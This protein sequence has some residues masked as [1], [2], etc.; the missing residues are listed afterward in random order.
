MSPQHP[1]AERLPF[2][3]TALPGVDPAWS[4][5]LTVAATAPVEPVAGRR[6]RWHVLDNA[7]AIAASG[8]TPQGIVL[9]VH[10]NPTWSYLW[11]D[12]LRA[13][14]EAERPWRVVAVDQ[15]DMG[16]SE[17]TGLFRRLE[18]RVQDL[19]DLT[20]ALG[21]D[22][23][24]VPVVTLAHDW[25]GLI[26]QGWA[27]EHPEIHAATVLTNT[28]VHHDNAEP[29]P[30]AL[31]LA[32]NRAVHEPLTSGSTA[33]LD[34][35]LALC[36][37]TASKAVK[38]A[39]KAPYT[40]RE[41]REGIAHFVADIP[42]AADHPSHAAYERIAGRMSAREVPT[43]L[44]WGTGDP[45]FQQRYLDDLMRRA[46]HADV[47]R[48]EGAK[49]LLPEARD[50]ATPL[51][52]WLD[53]RFGGVGSVLAAHRE[54]RSRGRADFVPFFAELDARRTDDSPAV[55]DMGPVATTV[56]G[57]APSLNVE[58]SV[59]WA[60][61][62]GSVDRLAVALLRTGVRPGDRVNLMV[63]PG[64]ML[65]TL[66]YACLRI[67]A[68]IV[69]ADQGLGRKGLT[70][71]LRGS[72]PRWFIGIRKA[73]V[74]ARAL[75]WPGTRISADAMDPVS[76][77]LLGVTHT[78]AELMDS[79]TTVDQAEIPAVD[80]DA[81]AAV[82]FTS[83]STGPAKG[84]VYTHRQMAGM[85]DTIRDTY[86]LRAGTGLVA[87]F[88]PFALLGPALGAASVTPDMD[89]TS[90]KT[91]TAR[92]LAQATM[93]IRAT[94]V[95]ASPAAIANVL[96]T[97]D[98]LS[99]AERD[100]LA[101][102]DLM[103]SAGAPIPEELLTRLQE[104]MPAAQLHTPYGM[105][106]ALPL[107]DVSLDVIRAAREDTQRGVEGAGR[108]VCV[109][110]PVEGAQLGVLPLRAD[111]SVSSE[112]VTTPGVTG[113]IVARAPHA[114]DHYDRLWITERASDLTPGWHRTGDVGHFDARERLWYEG[115]LAHV[116]TMSHGPV[117]SVAA[118]HAAQT[119]PGV[120]RV[121]VVGVGPTGSQ[122]A[123]AVIETVPAASGPALADAE[124]SERVRATVD[125]ATGLP[126]SAVLVIPEQPT[127]IRHNSK[128]DRAELSDWAERALA[129]GKLSAL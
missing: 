65:T 99:P 108:G 21:I 127:D 109:G 42:A 75:G 117:S 129:T 88:A 44:L 116:I 15:L 90:P 71:A 2:T 47:H 102:V 118:E 8:R 10:G 103:L 53:E 26:S 120:G 60:Q 11:R 36:D 96:A 70:R 110:T 100:A 98:E 45:V 7:D 33:F 78:V 111:G 57:S 67:G 80:A 92:A 128:I 83:G 29:I 30:S 1:G 106:E 91:L 32:L 24:D 63:P 104:L 27:Q 62:S 61:L 51:L 56:D 17:R 16:F 18:D 107:T 43:L 48:F 59:S 101:R 115:R 86:G 64:S 84:V 85:R 52:T 124:L 40:S 94:A 79:V 41:R 122:S 112:I 6:R 25:G 66:I 28:A 119:V 113:E 20:H 58:R 68:V 73:L 121:A 105:T 19:G 54:Q 72:S 23:A 81:E 114:K 77:K 49:H 31:R 97:A 123:V 46:P 87:G 74:G 50:I 9:A 3:E 69:V 126:V 55:V 22:D 125:M 12:V 82:L 34:T 35:T 13:A 4:R 93:A 5:T 14:Q 39:Y 38:R 95:F 37:P 76:K 89:V